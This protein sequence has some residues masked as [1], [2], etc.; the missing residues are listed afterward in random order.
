MK[1]DSALP[2]ATYKD[3]FGLMGVSQCGLKKNYPK[4][5][6]LT[7][8]QGMLGNGIVQKLIHL[9]EVGPLENTKLY[10]ASRK[11][12]NT[13]IRYCEKDIYTLIA[14]SEI[15]TIKDAIDIVIHTASPSN[16]TQIHSYQELYDANLGILEKIRNINP[17]R[18]IYLSSSE[19]YKGKTMLEGDYYLNFDIDKKRDWYPIAKIKSEQFLKNCALENSFSVGIVRLFHTFGPGV[20]RNDGRSFADILWGAE[21]QRKITLHSRGEQVRSFLYLGDAVDAILNIAFSNE[22][23][24]KIINLGSTQ[25]VSIF[26]FAEIVSCITG[27][28]IN[29]DFIS[30]F[31]HSTNDYVVP[32]MKNM[33]SYEWNAKVGIWEGIESTLNWIKRSTGPSW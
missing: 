1:S 7:G 21:V 8:S 29:Y 18:V 14:N 11:W 22:S 25:P 23:G 17:N 9:K 27:S 28:K 10:F 24:Y 26:E 12:P 30:E 6:L 20:K 32:I 3:I 2:I 4:S 5:I 13:K 31:P 16:V 19:V 15:Q 33:N